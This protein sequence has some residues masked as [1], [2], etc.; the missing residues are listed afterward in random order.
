MALPKVYWIIG[1]AGAVLLVVGVW[2]LA[3]WGGVRTTRAVSDI[4]SVALGLFAVTCVGMA[5]RSSRGRDRVAWICLTIGL[6]GWFVGD[7]IWGH[8][9]QW[10]RVNG[11]IPSVADGG[12]LV[13][14]V[15]AC[16]ALVLFPIGYRGQSQ[17]RLVLDGLIVAGSLFL[18]SW[19]SV[20]HAVFAAHSVSHFALGL[21]LAYPVSDLVLITVA[22]LVLAR[23]HTGQRATMTLLTAGIALIALSDSAFVYLLAH[24]DYVSGSA[25]DLGWLAG[26]L[27]L[28]VAALVRVPNLEADLEAAR[29]P[30]RV[31]LWLPNVPLLL[32]GVVGTV[33]LLP[34]PGSIPV[35]GV[36]LLLV[37]AV[38]V[39]Q[40]LVVG[41]NRRLLVM[42]A[43]Q[44]LRDPL[45]GL[46][47]R[48]L[49]HDRL[50]HA[51]K[52]RNRDPRALAVLLLDLNDF[53]LVND[54]LG[55]QAG[56]AL[57]IGVADRILGCL[58]TSDTVGRLGGDEFAILIERD[59]S[60]SVVANR[61]IDTFD[62]PF[63]IDGQQLLIRPSVGLAIASAEIP[64][65]SADGLLKQADVAMYSAKRAAAGGVH[66]FTPGMQM[67]NSKELDRPREQSGTADRAAE[68][69]AAS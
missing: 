28:G 12:Y 39:R 58:R 6:I 32:A 35:L 31:A 54:S 60:P 51:L 43:D 46:A 63:T 65:V 27:L 37:S 23:T 53:K 38:L 40:F 62:E 24:N 26:L 30:S 13:F 8:Y 64:D 57:L 14:P 44:A 3:G 61:V 47:N 9:E 50:T 20:L 19:V 25:I 52:S 18:V 7:V 55:H 68:A 10:G 33:Y 17:T 22:V 66:T 67:I 15:A 69:S 34:S 48:T 29:V 2:L 42:V 49:F 1:F 5:A 56:D 21:A 4:G 45:T 41:E 16:L 11:P 59:D 36:A